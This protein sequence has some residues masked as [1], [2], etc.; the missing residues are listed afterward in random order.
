MRV[1]IMFF[2]FM[3]TTFNVF[4]YTVSFWHVLVFGAL[5]SMI[6]YFIGTWFR[7]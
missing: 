2:E 1:Y 6:G 4:G 5:S 3:N 7:R